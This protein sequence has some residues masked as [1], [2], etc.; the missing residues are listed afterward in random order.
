MS[1]ALND[2]DGIINPLKGIKRIDVEILPTPYEAGRI[3][4]KLKFV[5]YNEDHDDFDFKSDNEK[6]AAEVTFY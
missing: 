1:Y 5:K 3:K 4:L 2:E 6:I